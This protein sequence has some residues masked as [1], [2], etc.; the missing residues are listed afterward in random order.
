[1][2]IDYAYAGQVATVV[3]LS[4]VALKVITGKL[5]EFAVYCDMEERALQR[6]REHRG[7]VE[8]DTPDYHQMMPAMKPKKV[9]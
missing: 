9:A 4:L 2:Y 6:D 7:F 3:V 8:D 1:M 5:I